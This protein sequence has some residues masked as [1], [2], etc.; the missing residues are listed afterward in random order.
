M[1][2][3]H[4]P[5]FGGTYSTVGSLGL[6]VNYYVHMYSTYVLPLN[7]SYCSTDISTTS[8]TVVVPTIPYTVP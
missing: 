7:Y 4:A 2:K 8:T 5:F 1:Q 3:V 6:T